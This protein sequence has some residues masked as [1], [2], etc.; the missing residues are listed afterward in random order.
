MLALPRSQDVVSDEAVECKGSHNK[1]KIT[2]QDAERY[3]CVRGK[4]AVVEILRQNRLHSMEERRTDKQEDAQDHHR[5]QSSPFGATVVH[6]L[7][8]LALIA[9]QNFLG[10]PQETGFV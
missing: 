8:S 6:C 7:F 1:R 9:G 10:Q 3:F 5:I 4:L 2:P